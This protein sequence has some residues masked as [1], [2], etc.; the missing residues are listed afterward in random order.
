MIMAATPIGTFND[1]VTYFNAGSAGGAG[2]LAAWTNLEGLLDVSLIVKKVDDPKDVLVPKSTVMA[3][4]RGQ[5]DTPIFTTLTPPTVTKLG[6]ASAVISGTGQYKDSAA[7]PSEDL[8][9]CFVLSQDGTGKWLILHVWGGLL[10]T[11]GAI[12]GTKA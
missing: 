10:T 1:A 6:L 7:A 12:E 3:Y 11:G 4:L 9:Y 5:E 8:A 2:A